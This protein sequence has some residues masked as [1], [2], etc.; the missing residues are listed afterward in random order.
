MVWTNKWVRMKFLDN[1]V[2]CIRKCQAKILSFLCAKRYSQ[3]PL[4]TTLLPFNECLAWVNLCPDSSES[5]NNNNKTNIYI[6]LGDR[7][8]SKHSAC[9]NSLHSHI[10]S[11]KYVP[12]SPL[13]DEETEHRDLVSHPRQWWRQPDPN[14]MLWASSVLCLM[15]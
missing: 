2:L 7:H 3:I 12:L 14:F 10:N 9:L 8:Y 15:A 5:C 6:H 11:P 4:N 13:S 1:R